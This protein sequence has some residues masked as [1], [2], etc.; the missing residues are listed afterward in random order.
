[1]TSV[2]SITHVGQ[3]DKARINVMKVQ[4]QVPITDHSTTVGT[5]PDDTE[6]KILLDSNTTLRVSC[7]NN[8]I[9]EINPCMDY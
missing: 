9:L 4:G 7:Q 8:T 1:M 5:L 3:T 2:V 6:C